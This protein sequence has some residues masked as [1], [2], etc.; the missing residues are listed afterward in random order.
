MVP[1]EPLIHQEK[2]VVP[3]QGRGSTEISERVAETV[4]SSRVQVGLVHV[5]IMH[6]SASLMICEDA[7]PEVRADL[8]RFFS[9]LVQD[10][11]ERFRH[12]SE[13]ADDMS[14]HVR[15]ILTQTDL[16]IP[17][18]DGRLALGTWQGIF[19]WEHRYRAYDRHVVVTVS[20]SPAA[21]G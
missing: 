18:T 21:T 4:A 11:D 14:A 17:V 7:D 16:M 15:S 8:E 13:G 12:R 1:A 10:G 5:F 3:M 20:G 6:T 9:D 19:V 2:I